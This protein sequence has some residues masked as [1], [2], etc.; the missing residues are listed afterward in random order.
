MRVP[1][2]PLAQSRGKF[3]NLAPYTTYNLYFYP[4][5]CLE[6]DSTN[7]INADRLQLDIV[8]DLLTGSA[9]LNVRNNYSNS[10]TKPILATRAN[11]GI[12]LPTGQIAANLANFDNAITMAGVTAAGPVVDA[13]LGAL[14]TSPQPMGRG[15]G[16]QTAPGLGGGRR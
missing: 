8:V 13:M 3:L 15:G 5:G 4:F 7:L 16:G 12:Q 10:S 6:I 9:V 2:H 14:N 1:K 11:L